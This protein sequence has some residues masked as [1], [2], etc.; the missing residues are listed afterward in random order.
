[1]NKTLQRELRESDRK[2]LELEK[3]MQRTVCLSHHDAVAKIKESS[4]RMK[5][6]LVKP[7]NKENTLPNAK[8]V[9]RKKVSTSQ[10]KKT[11]RTVSSAHPLT[12]KTQSK[13]PL[14]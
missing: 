13:S 12:K 11:T 10:L 2:M 4:C 8:S 5:D 9:D 3:E 7:H 14:I 1:M 6:S